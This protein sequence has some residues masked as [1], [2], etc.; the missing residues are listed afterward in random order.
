MAKNFKIADLKAT[1][2]YHVSLIDKWDGHAES[3]I[4]TGEE[5]KS[6]TNA[7]AHL[8]DIHAEER[9]EENNMKEFTM[10]K[11]EIK[12]DSE[13]RKQETA[14]Y[15]ENG[16]FPT[17]AEEHRTDSER[18]L[19]AYSTACRWE[20]YQNKAISREKAVEFAT[21]RALKEIEKK[22]AQSLAQLDRIA[23][24]AELESVQISV[25]W[26]RSRT[27]GYNPHVEAYTNTGRHTGTASGYGYDKE[28]TAIAEALNDCESVLKALYTL[29]EKGLQAGQSDESATACCG[30]DNRDICG[31]GAGYGV[32]PYFEGGVG[33]SCFWAIFEKCGYKVTGHHGKKSDFYTIERKVEQ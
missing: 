13:K 25:D 20:Q 5:L 8:Y 1:S 2:V 4:M 21:K 22:T 11:A 7:A 28:S 15:I 31:Y 27:W 32:I 10:M 29:K 23:N 17:W 3:R 19:K 18:G 14:F 26:V 12:Q 16:Y 33:S 9:E 24:A 30:R 6:F